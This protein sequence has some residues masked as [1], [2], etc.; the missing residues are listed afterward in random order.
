MV[1]SSDIRRNR[2]K[3]TRIIYTREIGILPEKERL[4]SLVPVTN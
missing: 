1:L 3:N 4:S 2:T